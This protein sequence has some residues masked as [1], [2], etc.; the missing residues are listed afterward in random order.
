MEKAGRAIICTKQLLSILTRILGLAL[1]EFY[2]GISERGGLVL[3]GRTRPT[4]QNKAREQDRERKIVVIFIIVK[5]FRNGSVP[6]TP[7]VVAVLT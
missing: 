4:L 1:E 3:A 5:A 2:G 6:R 7:G